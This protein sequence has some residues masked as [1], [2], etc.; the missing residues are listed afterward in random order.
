MSTETLLHQPAERSRNLNTAGGLASRSLES[1][2]GSRMDA[3]KA[4]SLDQRAKRQ[5]IMQSTVLVTAPKETE[6]AKP[7][8]DISEITPY[9]A[10]SRI[11]QIGPREYVVT[12]GDDPLPGQSNYSEGNPIPMRAWHAPGA[13]E[14]ARA[15]MEAGR[16][17]EYVMS[18]TEIADLKTAQIN[19]RAFMQ[20][21]AKKAG[22]RQMSWEST[23]L[24]FDRQ[25]PYE[26]VAREMISGVLGE[27]ALVV[28]FGPHK[29]V[30]FAKGQ[31]SPTQL[32]NDMR[33]AP[34][35]AYEKHLPHLAEAQKKIQQ[36]R[37]EDMSMETGT[38]KGFKADFE[39]SE[40]PL[41]QAWQADNGWSFQWKEIMKP[42]GTFVALDAD[43]KEYDI[44]NLI[45][46]G[47]AQDIHPH[48]AIYAVREFN[49]Q[50][51]SGHDLVTV[52]VNFQDDAVCCGFSSNAQQ[53]EVWKSDAQQVISEMIS[54]S[55]SVSGGGSGGFAAYPN[56]EVYYAKDYCS[57]CKNKKDSEGNCGKCSSEKSKA[58]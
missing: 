21:S 39:G 22:V 16:T 40:A 51:E 57:S 4:P 8:V 55:G 38:G 33:T 31:F 37:K 12:H 56:G 36:I 54:E 32:I 5:E 30:G 45:K 17:E 1:L 24:T 26:D 34:I 28:W 27:D 23:G 11:V 18:T 48:N 14:K 46:L 29:A 52:E 15:I 2:F 6:K 49:G 41:K 53:S 42:D 7:L 47:Y 19:T 25:S 44:M 50:A 9:Y 43:G 58:A 10:D 3:V 35:E 20:V 13:G